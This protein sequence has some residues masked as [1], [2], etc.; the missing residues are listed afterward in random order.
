MGGGGE[1]AS[2]GTAACQLRASGHN[3]TDCVF[4]RLQARTVAACI[5]PSQSWASLFRRGGPVWV[6]G[7]NKQGAHSQLPVHGNFSLIPCVLRGSKLSKVVLSSVRGMAGRIGQ[8]H[9]W[10]QC[11]P[12]TAQA[13]FLPNTAGKPPAYPPL[14]PFPEDCNLFSCLQHSTSSH[15]QAIPRSTLLESGSV[16]FCGRGNMV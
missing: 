5:V 14:T 7:I 11:P 13:F 12:S 8:V 4:P 1:A 15:V 2:P 3:L 6:S 9:L 16:C 10:L